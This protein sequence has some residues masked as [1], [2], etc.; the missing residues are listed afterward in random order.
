M[1]TLIEHRV[2]CGKPSYKNKMMFNSI[3]SHKEFIHFLLQPNKYSRFIKEKTQR[4][5]L[6]HV[7]YETE[8]HHI[9]LYHAGGT[10]NKFN[11]VRLTCDEHL[12]AHKLLF[13]V[14]GLLADQYVINMRCKNNEQSSYLRIKLSHQMSK[15]NKTGFNN[16]CQQK[17]RGKKGGLVRS[18][19]KDTSFE[20]KLSSECRNLLARNHSWVF[21]KT[22]YEIFIQANEFF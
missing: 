13:Q 11:K 5:Q 7:A 18:K 3:T 6:E 17:A 9:I 20:K 12:E 16:I 4:K 10:D 22:G 1:V 2:N 21:K 15:K 8:I 19:A 14:Y